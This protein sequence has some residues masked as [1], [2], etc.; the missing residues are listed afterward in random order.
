MHARLQP[1]ARAR[2]VVIDMLLKSTCKADLVFAEELRKGDPP[3]PG[4]GVSARHDGDETIDRKWR[5]CQR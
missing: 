1:V 3:F 5:C 2:R 4:H